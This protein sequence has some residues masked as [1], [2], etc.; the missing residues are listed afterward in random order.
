M[1]SLARV[2]LAGKLLGRRDLG[3]DGLAIPTDH[4]RTDMQH[5]NIAGLGAGEAKRGDM[6]PEPRRPDRQFEL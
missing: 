1:S 6:G 2:D 4:P 5:P 3:P